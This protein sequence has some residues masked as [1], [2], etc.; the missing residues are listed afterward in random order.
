MNSLTRILIGAIIVGVVCI[1]SSRAQESYEK[2][3]SNLGAAVGVPLTPTSNYVHAGWGVTGG[4]GYNFSAHHSL[5][6][7]FMWNRL[8]AT[9]AALQPIW[10]ASQNNNISGQ[11]TVY[12]VTGNYRFELQGKAMGPYFI[13]GGGLY[14]RTT[15]L[16]K[17]VASGTSTV[18]A[19]A[20][21]WWGFNCTSGIVTT[22]QQIAGAGS[23][24]MGVNGG[25]GFTVRVG[26]APYRLFVESRYHY[27]PNKPTSTQLVV[28]TVGI[29]Y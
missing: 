22:S 28:L 24:A 3:N 6:G 4:V 20:W 7:E 29:R 27:A 19:P 8:Y 17:P 12:A 13:G 18:C 15:S 10:A 14:Y 1:Q 21:P 23:T 11:S 26:E 16:S 2:L 9:D 25:I 5:I